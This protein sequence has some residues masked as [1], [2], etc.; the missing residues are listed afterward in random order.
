MISL[1]APIDGTNTNGDLV[2]NKILWEMLIV[3]LIS[4]GVPLSI[5]ERKELKTFLGAVFEAPPSQETLYN[6]IA[7]PL[8]QAILRDVWH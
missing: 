1:R 5:V 6:Q 3:G 7:F 8:E 4:S 2:P